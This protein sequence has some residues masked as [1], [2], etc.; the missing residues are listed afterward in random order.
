MKPRLGIFPAFLLAL[1]MAGTPS[2]LF[3]AGQASEF[4]DIHPALKPDADRPG[5][6][7]WQQPGFDRARYTK[8]MFEPLSIFLDPESE[9]KG[10]N[11][12]D[13]KA[14]A[15]GFQ[16]AVVQTLEPE[17]PVVEVRGSGV[18]YVRAAL[19]HVKLKK[20]SRGLLGYTP[21]GLIVTGVQDAAGKRISLEN[22]QFELEAYD[23]VSGEPVAV[24]IDSHPTPD[25]EQK[26]S[27]KGI[28][29][30]FK[31]YA[32]RFKSRMLA[33]QGKNPR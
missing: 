33:A 15:A 8:V 30:T 23:G 17:L 3:A 21:I 6:L 2:V 5:A 29:D 32:T 18:L 1:A 16:D 26:L 28:E 12:D 19:T 10:L 20:P 11:A 31:F 27:W 7:V 14:L 24:I 25:S 4:L 13:V 9:Y 22:A